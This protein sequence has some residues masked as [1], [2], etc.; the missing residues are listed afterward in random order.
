[1]CA[2]LHTHNTGARRWRQHLKY[3]SLCILCCF[4]FLISALEEVI[5][6]V[7]EFDVDAG[8][9]KVEVART[10]TLSNGRLAFRNRVFLH[11]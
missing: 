10:R 2:P 11:C 3:P 7:I 5:D 9:V 8:M 4:C 1:L 6:F